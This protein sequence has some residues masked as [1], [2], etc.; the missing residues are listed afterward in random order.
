MNVRM[1]DPL[2]ATSNRILPHNKRCLV[3]IAADVKIA[4]PGLLFC[5]TIANKPVFCDMS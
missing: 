2:V 3:L 4:S 5:G 1:P